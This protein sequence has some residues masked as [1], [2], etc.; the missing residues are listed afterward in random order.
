MRSLPKQFFLASESPRR[1]KILSEEGY[2]FTVLPIKVSER[3]DKNLNSEGQVRAIA[4]EKMW[5]AREA[6]KLLKSNI[7]LILTADTMV[8]HQGVP[9]GKPVDRQDAIQTLTR[10]SNSEHLV[11][12]AVCVFD[13]ESGQHL[14]QIATTKVLFK[15]LSQ[16][17][18]VTYVESGSPMDKAGS[19]GAQDE[20]RNFIAKIE[21]DFDTVVGL[22]M[23]LVREMLSKFGV[24]P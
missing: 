2:Q 12:T 16:N 8:Y 9:L 15:A 23:N 11:H 10:L 19:Y 4:E 3:I 17:E 7:F 18:I 1:R 20:G 6:T 14:T 21:G 24:V 5:A 22:P 13:S